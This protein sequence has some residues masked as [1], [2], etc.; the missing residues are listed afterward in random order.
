MKRLLS[1]FPWLAVVALCGCTPMWSIR[2]A[3]PVSSPSTQVRIEDL[4]PA[5]ARTFRFDSR[6]RWFF[7]DSNTTPDRISYLRAQVASAIVEPS[8]QEVVVAVYRFDILQDNSKSTPSDVGLIGGGNG[9]L[10]PVP[11]GYG[12]DSDHFECTLDA[13]IFSKRRM[14]EARAD[15]ASG[16]FDTQNSEPVRKA[17]QACIDSAIKAWASISM[18]PHLDSADQPVTDEP[19]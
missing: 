16:V 5:Q 17:A 3:T 6:T 13:E 4:R 11:M 8:V 12:G 14:V 10:I 18:G 2:L 9:V 15:F 7:A 1:F 19:K